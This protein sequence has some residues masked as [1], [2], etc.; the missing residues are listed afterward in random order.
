MN[1]GKYIKPNNFS[2]NP[3]SSS[4]SSGAATQRYTP[5]Q[6]EYIKRK[7]YAQEMDKA[8]PQKSSSILGTIVIRPKGTKFGTQNPGEKVFVLVRRHWVANVGWIFRST[9]YLFSPFIVAALLPLLVDILNITNNPVPSRIWIIIIVS[10]YSVVLTLT[11]RHFV[12]WFYDILIVTNQR[13]LDYEFSPFSGYNIKE[14]ALE[15]IED[16]KEV[17]KDFWGGIFRY[18][19]IEATTASSDGKLNFEQVPH[20]TLVRD[21]LSDL[22][23]IA[24]KYKKNGD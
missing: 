24:K 13:I 5:E 21:I 14:A 22:A 23:N 1:Q 19:D 18:G 9:L 16:I 7:M 15:N 17:S 11:I 20:V 12:E 8:I 10:Y 6:I 4:S 2:N 3:S